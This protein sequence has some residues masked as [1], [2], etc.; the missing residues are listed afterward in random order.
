MAAPKI[1]VKTGILDGVM[2]AG[3]V[4]QGLLLLMLSLSIVSWAIIITKRRQLKLM[5][6]ANE[7]FVDA[8]WKAASLEDMAKKAKDYQN[9]NIAVVFL[10]AFQELQRIAEK[11]LGSKSADVGSDSSTRLTGIDNL[12]RTIRKVSDSEIAKAE[13][14]LSFLAT[15]GST[16]PFIGLLGTVIGIMTSFQQIAASGSASLAV[17]APGISEALFATAIGLFAALPA[18]A[19]YNYFVGQ[20]KRIEM[21]VAS[22]GS[23]FL[24]VAKRNF[25]RES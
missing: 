17:V 9:S 18:V 2:G 23:D 7:T 20:V 15:V 8:F 13:A 4:V 1:A 3:P 22:F 21:G 14:N 5:Y 12:E 11:S 25:F 19:A 24:N 16:S 6:E 10:A